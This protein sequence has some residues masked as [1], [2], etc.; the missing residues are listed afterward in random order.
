MKENLAG[1]WWDARR[2]RRLGAGAIANRQRAR[3][4]E[5]VAH[6]RAASPYY[7]E[8]YSGLPDRI[9]EPTLLPI[10]DKTRLMARFDEWATDREVTLARAHAFTDDPAQAGGRFLGSYLL[11][12]TSGTTGTHGVFVIDDRA[13]R[14]NAA[15]TTPMAL[16]WLGAGGVARLL[17]RGGRIA[18]VVATGGHSF[19]AASTARLASTSPRISRAVRVFPADTPMPDLVAGLNAYQPLALVGYTS[20]VALLAAEQEAGRLQISPL[21]V[22][23]SGETLVAADHS[24]ISAAFGPKVLSPYGATECPF[25]ANSCEAGWCHVNSD[26][27]LAEPVDADYRPTPPGELSHTL[28]VSNL[29]NRVQPILRYDLGDSVLLKPDAC[30]CGSPL[31]AIRVQGRAADVITLTSHGRQFGFPP[32]AFVALADHLPGV[33]Q[34][35]LMQTAPGRLRVRL[36]PSIGTDPDLVGQRML[37]EF[38]ALLA[39]HGLDDII[40]ERGPEAPQQSASGK[41]RTVIPLGS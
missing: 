38:A 28:L 27:V 11:A 4:A 14:V 21:L 1:L 40:L 9:E 30:P 25:L 22:E 12:T 23:P 31:P 34:F 16:S 8:L 10:T 15:L 37:A 41:Y 13:A 26:W 20:L 17:A 39:R 29:A 5:I 35:Q 32:L 33:E 7:G 19:G 36:R 18:M 6:A 3:L 2:A 24:R